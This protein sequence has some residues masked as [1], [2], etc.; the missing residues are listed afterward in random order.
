MQPCTSVVQLSFEVYRFQDG[1]SK[2]VDAPRFQSDS[3]C[4]LVLAVVKAAAKKH[5]VILNT[6]YR[7]EIFVKTLMNSYSRT[8]G[9]CG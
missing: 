4:L 2:H 7:F 5:K 8:V 6:V 1:L 9:T 3:D